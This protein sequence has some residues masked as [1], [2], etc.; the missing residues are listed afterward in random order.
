MTFYRRAETAGEVVQRQHSLKAQ[1][2]QTKELAEL[3]NQDLY[4][5]Y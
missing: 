1:E 5:C 3:G 2:R 4:I